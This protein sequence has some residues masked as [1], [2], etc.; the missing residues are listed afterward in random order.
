MRTHTSAAD[1][2]RLVDNWSDALTVAEVVG[3]PFLRVTDE[4]D[5]H[6][7]EAVDVPNGVRFQRLG[8]EGRVAEAVVVRVEGE[9]GRKRVQPASSGESVP[10]WLVS[11]GGEFPRGYAESD[12]VPVL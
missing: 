8:D 5:L 2:V 6:D 12:F 7:W 4:W 3:S 10:T 1:L 11:V 9:P